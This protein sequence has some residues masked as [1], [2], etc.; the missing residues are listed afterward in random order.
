MVAA[1]FNALAG[2]FSKGWDSYSRVLARHPLR[3]QVITSGVL[4]AIGDLLAQ[5]VDHDEHARSHATR[6]P[7]AAAA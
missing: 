4:Y 5:R 2:G 3:T 1:A 7:A 6:R